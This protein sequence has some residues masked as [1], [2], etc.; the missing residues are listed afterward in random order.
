M[1]GTHTSIPLRSIHDGLDTIFDGWHLTDLLELYDKGGLEAIHRYFRE[2]GRRYGY[3]R[4]TSPFTVSL[5]VARLMGS[6]RLE[7]A[8]EVLLHDPK[9]Y[10]PPWNQIDA[11]AGSTAIVATSSRRF[12]TTSCP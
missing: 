12:A 7:E 8:A 2:G 4:T 11:L 1:K 6:G 3:Y 10:P 9:A 5:I